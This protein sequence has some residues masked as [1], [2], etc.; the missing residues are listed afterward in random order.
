M[1]VFE[2]VRAGFVSAKEIQ[3]HFTER[4]ITKNEVLYYL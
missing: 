4:N 3:E 1:T 2:K